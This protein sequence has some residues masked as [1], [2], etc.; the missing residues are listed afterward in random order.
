MSMDR[1]QFLKLGLGTAMAGLAA[2]HVPRAF[3]GGAGD[4]RVVLFDAFPIFD[5]RPV[6]ARANAMFP[7]ES[8]FTDL[9]RT[10]QFEYTWLRTAS[11][12]YRD[13]FSVTRDALRFAARAKK[14]P[15]SAADEDRLMGAYLELEAWPDALPTLRALRGAGIR[16]GFLSNFTRGMLDSCIRHA[17]LD[18]LFDQVLSTDAAQAFKPSPLA[19][20]LGTDTFGLERAQ[21]AFAA[22]AGWDAAGAKSFGYPVFWVNRLRQP[23]EELGVGAD[24]EDEDL[25]GLVAFVKARA[26][27]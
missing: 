23:A 22:F 13:F 4:V 16:T 17:G 2:T 6:F 25:S 21:I 12:A 15:L 7:A 9:W 8:G 24:A 5:P 27:V 19:Y 10:K 18:G 14:L 26:A 3:A 1:R 11:G 20:R